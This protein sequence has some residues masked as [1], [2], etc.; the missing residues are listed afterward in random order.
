MP[1]R[2]QLTDDEIVARARPVF[3]ERG[4]AARTQQIAAAVGLT[5][6]AIALRFGTKRA[7]FE[8]TLAAPVHGDEEGDCP[9]AGGGDKADAA[10]L[11]GQLERLRAHLGERWPQRLQFRLA[12]STADTRDETQWIA[13]RVAARLQAHARRGAIRNDIGTDALAQLLIALLTGDVAQ[14]FAAREPAQA[15]DPAF[16]DGVLRLLCAD[17]GR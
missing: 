9:Q 12:S 7:L 16:M 11:P 8:R 5:W 10:D 17:G 14:R 3:I 2:S 4:F 13:Q 15:S 6:G 1:R